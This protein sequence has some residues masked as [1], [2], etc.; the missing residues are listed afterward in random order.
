MLGA[1]AKG[2]TY[3]RLLGADGTTV[4][5]NDDSCS[6]LASKLTYTVPQSANGTYT[7]RVGC[8]SQQACG[9]TVAFSVQ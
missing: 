4:S 8:Y 9:G 7:I 1:S 3:L 5:A 2:D 6:S